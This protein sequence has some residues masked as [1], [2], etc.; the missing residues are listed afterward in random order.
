MYKN[1]GGVW[2]AMRMTDEENRTWGVGLRET[3][4]EIDPSSIAT[5]T[6]Q[7]VYYNPRLRGNG[8]IDN[9]CHSR[10]SRAITFT[11]LNYS[12]NTLDST[13]VIILFFFF[14]K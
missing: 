7:H 10:A 8:T 11:W 1:G 13:V 5:C 9:R 12:R 6:P 3:I 4:D 14:K 2:T